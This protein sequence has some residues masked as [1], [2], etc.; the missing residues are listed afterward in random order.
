MLGSM[1]ST[2]CR[3]DEAVVGGRVRII[4][5]TDLCDLYAQCVF[6]A[7]E[8]FSFDD[9]GELQF[10]SDVGSD[11]VAKAREA[12]ALCPAAAIEVEA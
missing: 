6:A 4:V 9:A 7:P 12:A 5:D 10:V 1:A 3:T 2:W 11:L 8:I